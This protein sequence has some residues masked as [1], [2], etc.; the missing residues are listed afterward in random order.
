MGKSKKK[1]GPKRSREATPVPK[2]PTAIAVPVNIGRSGVAPRPTGPDPSTVHWSAPHGASSAI[3]YQP[4]QHHGGGSSSSWAQQPHSHGGPESS[5]FHP[6]GD[7]KPPSARGQPSHNKG[8][9]GFSQSRPPSGKKIARPFVHSER[10]ARMHGNDPAF[11]P[12]VYGG[13]GHAGMRT[14]NPIPLPAKPPFPAKPSVPAAPP[15]SY[16]HPA[17]PPTAAHH[18]VS[19]KKPAQTAPPPSSEGIAARRGSLLEHDTPQ[20]VGLAALLVAPTKKPPAAPVPAGPPPTK[21]A[22]RILNTES[23]LANTTRLDLEEFRKELEPLLPS[24]NRIMGHEWASITHNYLL[25]RNSAQVSDVGS[26]AWGPAAVSE[27]GVSV[28]HKFYIAALE[29]DPTLQVYEA[30]LELDPYSP[31]MCESVFDVSRGLPQS[32]VSKRIRIRKTVKCPG[33]QSLQC[34]H[35]SHHVVTAFDRRAQLLCWNYNSQLYGSA[36]TESIALTTVG[37][38]NTCGRMSVGPDD[39]IVSAGEGGHI[40]SWYLGAGPVAH[41]HGSKPGGKE[42]HLPKSH[43]RINVA[44]LGEI[45][46]VAVYDPSSRCVMAAT[47]R[48]NIAFVDF[49]AANGR[50]LESKLGAH[51]EEITAIHA[52][53]STPS[54]SGGN[55]MPAATGAGNGMFITGSADKEVHIWD[56]RYMRKPLQIHKH[57]ARVTAVEW[58]PHVSSMYLS[59]SRD[60]VVEIQRW[61]AKTTARRD[62]ET[63]VQ[64]HVMHG[65]APVV[66]AGW[67]P[68]PR[69]EGTVLSVSAALPPPPSPD[70]SLV[71]SPSIQVWRGEGYLDELRGLLSR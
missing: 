34:L 14:G 13:T 67:N 25:V 55:M 50:A 9:A 39:G 1:K 54:I 36:G 32:L 57:R 31:A 51:S 62:G 52:R 12:P 61:D 10:A 5:H 7:R 48:G 71:A 70:G 64:A 40:F 47:N 53:T 26:L 21:K 24:R 19:P 17:S 66:A 41:H 42:T 28:K 56:S 27:D 4:P 20:L 30:N 43:A 68:D 2:R 65:G 45:T 46:A 23:M 58:S 18:I 16:Q 38:I 3:P 22:R 15:S 44:E 11:R 69:L 6:Y 63:R 29:P 33:I 49:R 60:G 59:A 37:N 8:P 35:Q